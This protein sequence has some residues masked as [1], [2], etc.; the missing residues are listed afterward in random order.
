MTPE[1]HTTLSQAELDRIRLNARRMQAEAIAATFRA[2]VGW[3]ARPLRIAR[4][5]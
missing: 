4:H 1:L 5:A 2:L 3:I